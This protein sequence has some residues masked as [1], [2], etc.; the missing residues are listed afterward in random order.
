LSEDTLE[1]VEA[2]ASTRPL[3]WRD[4]LRLVVDDAAAGARLEAARVLDKVGAV[5]DVPRLRV[6]SRARRGS[7]NLGK[8]L[9]RLLAPRV[10][11]EDQGRVMIVVGDRR[12]VGT[13]IRRKVLAALIFLVSR[14]KFSAT[15]D[16]VLDALW[17]ELDP[18]VAV[19]SLNQTVY[20][21]RRVFEPTYKGDLSPEYVHHDSDVI[22]LD[23]ALVESRSAN[24][25]GM[26]ERMGPKPAPSD[27]DLLSHQYIGRF[28]LDFAYE[29][30]AVS[31]RD[32]LH[33]AY[34]QIIE[35]A[36]MA[37]TESG[38]FER[39]IQLARR[40]LAI[41]PEAEPL[42]A[43]LLRLYR[44]SGAHAA[45]AEQY[46]HYASTLRAELGIEPPPLES[47]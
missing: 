2:E 24:C 40:A 26:I 20:F 16:Q 18:E 7:S 12:T 8:G 3:P 38:H 25:W 11:V 39:G 35:N 42:E 5:E 19:N 45:A 17:P 43:F 27:V 46:V 33:A 37:D 34:L 6:M 28:A 23:P 47:V 29:D 21:L 44:L 15:R 32:G 30:W 36:V 10:F 22:W 13:H 14:P 1:L 4:A 9:A 41:D 31:Y